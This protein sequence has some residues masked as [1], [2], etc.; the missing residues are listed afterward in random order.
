MGKA[1]LFSCG[2]ISGDRYVGAMVRLLRRRFPD[3]DVF[4]LG[5][6]E[7]ASSGAQ[8]L[9]STASLST[10][11]LLEAIG[12]LRQWWKAWNLARLFIRTYRP[13]AVVLVDNP[14]FNFRLAHFC[15]KQRIPVVYFAPPQVWAWGK[16]RGWELARLADWIFPLF[17]WEVPYFSSG[18]ACVRWAGHPL[19]E[20]LRQGL[21]D[22]WEVFS[23]IPWVVLLPGSRRA[24]VLR[25]LEVVQEYLQ[26]NPSL[27][28]SYRLVAVAASPELRTLLTEKLCQF[29]VTVVMKKELPRVLRNASLAIA[30]A[31]TVTLEVALAGVPQ[32]IVYRLSPFTFW[33]AK[34]V[35][36]ES[37]IGLPNIVL[38][39]RIYPELIQ[40]DFSWRNLQREVE[41][42]L[43]DAQIRE[44]ALFWARQIRERLDRGDPF[45]QVVEVLGTYL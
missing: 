19:L 23:E 32:I 13:Q 14:G 2:D 33:V 28:D 8:L 9:Y 34:M 16:K 6:E 38:G 31:G 17:P 11:G 20:L 27:G 39:E 43:Q 26:R 45:A 21:P 1:I 10:F 36:Q 44:K 18:R 37:F 15:R 30:C 42:M 40:D 25:Y 22:I 29:S 4:A 35:F 5:G 41:N 3:V 12:S 7:S 24:E